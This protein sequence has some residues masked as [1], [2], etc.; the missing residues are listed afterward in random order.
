MSF[1][2]PVL[3]GP[4]ATAIGSA[5]AT[6][7]PYVAAIGSIYQA[8][9]NIALGN[10]QAAISAF[11]ADQSERAY[12]ERKDQRKR[13]LRRIVGQQRALYS[14]AGVSLEGTPTDIFADS[15]REMAYEN[16]ADKF[17]TYSNYVS[18]RMEADAY[19]RGGRMKAFGNLLDYTMLVA[20][21]GS[22]PDPADTTTTVFPF[23]ANVSDIDQAGRIRGGI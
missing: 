16:W 4:T 3:T 12:L 18:K 22:V 11:Q 14:A 13:Q 1:L 6:A 23:R 19:R 5:F 7:A 8:Q 17:D 21:R 10:Q 2:T 15:A 9:S 20:R